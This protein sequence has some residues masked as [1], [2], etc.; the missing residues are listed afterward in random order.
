M[1]HMQAK[2]VCI[3]AWEQNHCRQRLFALLELALK[4]RDHDILPAG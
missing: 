4:A 3:F 2:T 1:K